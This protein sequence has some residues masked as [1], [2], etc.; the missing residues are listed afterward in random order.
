MGAIARPLL[1]LAVA[2]LGPMLARAAVAAAG[3]VAGMW[4][5]VT[6]SSDSKD[7]TR[8]Q[9]HQVTEISQVLTRNRRC[10]SFWAQHHGLERVGQFCPECIGAQGVDSQLERV[11]RCGSGRGHGATAPAVVP[12]FTGQPSESLLEATRFSGSPTPKSERWI[13]SLS[14]L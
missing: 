10:L 4:A 1:R 7:D 11:P 2:E 8:Q 13:R 9:A 6:G 5:A 3:A 12:T 14:I